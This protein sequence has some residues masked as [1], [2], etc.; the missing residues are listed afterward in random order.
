MA[1]QTEAV[2]LRKAK[3]LRILRAHGDVHAKAAH[4]SIDADEE[5]QDLN[6]HEER[7]PNQNN[8]ES[9]KKYLKHT[10]YSGTVILDSQICPA[11]MLKLLYLY[12]LTE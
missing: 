1:W 11:N 10:K 12:L 5:V 7:V 9:T 6:T 2:R 4:T 8:P 3:G